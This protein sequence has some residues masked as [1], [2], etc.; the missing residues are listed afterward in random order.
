MT[1]SAPSSPTPESTEKLRFFHE[2]SPVFVLVPQDEKERREVLLA[3]DDDFSKLEVLP[4]VVTELKIGRL[5]SNAV[6]YVS[7]VYTERDKMPSGRWGEVTKTHVSPPVELSK[8]SLMGEDG[9]GS[10]NVPAVVDALQGCCHNLRSG[11]VYA[12]RLSA[13]KNEADKLAK[14]FD[15]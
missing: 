9:I 12:V 7:H 8:Y 5:P 1:K 2:K 11:K 6:L 10:V 14:L 4:K 3:L 13:D 15:N